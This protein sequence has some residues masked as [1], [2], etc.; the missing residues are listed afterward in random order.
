MKA[1]AGSQYSVN[2]ITKEEENE[3]CD[4]CITSLKIDG[5][6]SEQPIDTIQNK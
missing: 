2:M 4:S 1:I 5:W 3:E 6:K